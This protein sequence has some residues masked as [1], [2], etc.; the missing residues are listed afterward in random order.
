MYACNG[1]LF[2]H[3]SPVRGETFVTRKITR[4]AAKISLGLQ[5][6]LYVGN[7]DAERDWGHAQDYVEGMWLM[8]QQKEAEDFV[9]ATGKKITVRKFIEMSFKELGIDVIWEGKG[10]QEKGINKATGATIVEIDPK[11]YRPAEVDLLVGDATKAKEK[12]G[13]VPKRTVEQ[14]CKEMVLSDLE[15]FKRDKYLLEGGHKILNQHE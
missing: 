3:E 4:A 15:L 13:W 8:L 6:R 9:L 7:I 1:I 10:E 2:N 12:L 5:D 11:Y 14:L